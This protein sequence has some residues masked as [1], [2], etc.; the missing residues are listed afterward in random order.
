M[1]DWKKVLFE[2]NNINVAAITASKLVHTSSATLPVLAIDQ[3]TGVVT[4]LVQSTLATQAGNTVFTV[5]GSDD[6]TDSFNASADQIL[7][8]GQFGQIPTT[9][10]QNGTTT[11]ISFDPVT[12]YISGSQQLNVI[13][14]TTENT[15]GAPTDWSQLIGFVT[16]S[17]HVLSQSIS[18]LIPQIDSSSIYQNTPNNNVWYGGGGPI[19]GLDPNV[20]VNG[21]YWLSSSFVG[22]FSNGSPSISSSFGEFTGSV[23]TNS[24]S[25]G[26]LLD[27]QSQFNLASGSSLL[28]ANTGSLL[29]AGLSQLDNNGMTAGTIFSELNEQNVPQ[30]TFTD[31]GDVSNI[32]SNATRSIGLG[33]P[34]ATDSNFNDLT[35][36]GLFTANV[37]NV[38]ADGITLQQDNVSIINGGI[39]F[40]TSS[41]HTHVII[42]QTSIT[43]GLEV[44]GSINFSEESLP[45]TEDVG[46]GDF[47]L[48][49]Y[50][51][52]TGNFGTTLLG[53][54]DSNFSTPTALGAQ[55]TASVAPGSTLSASF[56]TEVSAAL[57]NIST[58]GTDQST[59]DILLSGS[60]NLTGSYAAGFLFATAS[61]TESVDAG[62]S[63]GFQ[64]PLLSTASF[65]ATSTANSATTPILTTTYDASTNTVSYVFNS[66]SFALTALNPDAGVGLFTSSQAIIDATEN[67]NAYGVSGSGIL[68]GSS[69]NGA[70]TNANV[71]Y[72]QTLPGALGSGQ[73]FLT[74]SGTPVSGG[75]DFFEMLNL[76]GADGTADTSLINGVSSPA[77]LSQGVIEFTLT[78]S[79]VFGVTASKMDTTGEP[80]FANLTVG[81]TADPGNLTVLGTV[82]NTQTTNLNVK[83][84]FILVNS[85]STQGAADNDND[86]DGGIIVDSGGGS[87]SLFMYDFT[88]KS[89]GIKGATSVDV[90]STA[91]S[92]AGGTIAPEVTVRAIQYGDDVAPP[93]DSDILYGKA[94]SNTVEGTMYI[95]NTD[96]PEQEVFIYA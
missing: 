92:D 19:T 93:A 52:A 6:S 73:T 38:S 11:T 8:A 95:S 14:Y 89:W 45:D 84:Q 36:Q 31:T 39:N 88:S 30:I 67:L 62:N 87:G 13:N 17:A 66:Q 91:S 50:D 75:G 94:S 59:I 58:A 15:T 33:T 53:G 40:G 55:I 86:N 16:T 56:A 69:T 20:G 96:L 27:S 43:G 79:V 28:Q 90:V 34:N 35:L 64:V 57:A 70:F 37:L 46:N 68:T 7:F 81:T 72:I 24:S 42:G 54:V 80:T 1:A 25:I 78:G 51:E 3:N 32:T 60:N 18:D 44:T 85:G 5:S 76:P 12:G 21:I 41:L 83:D 22:G 23:N 29:R 26:I 82:I 10:S 77:S 2:G 71:T 4:Q 65:I 61:D 48:L 74:G 9:V 47:K 49:V 63:D